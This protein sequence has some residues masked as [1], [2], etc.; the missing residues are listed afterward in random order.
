MGGK[1]GRMGNGKVWG[2]GVRIEQRANFVTAN[3]RRYIRVYCYFLIV[4]NYCI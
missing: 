2:K 1:D 4:Y 3:C